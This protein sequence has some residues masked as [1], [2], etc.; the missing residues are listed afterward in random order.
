MDRAIWCSITGPASHLELMWEE[1]RTARTFRSDVA[2]R[3]R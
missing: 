1:P 3:A 2:V